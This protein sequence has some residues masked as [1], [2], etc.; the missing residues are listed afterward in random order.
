M[1]NFRFATKKI[2]QKEQILRRGVRRLPVIESERAKRKREPAHTHTQ[3]K[4][5][6]ERALAHTAPAPAR[7]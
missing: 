3:N 6:R 5:A 4:R 2:G 1:L 7:A